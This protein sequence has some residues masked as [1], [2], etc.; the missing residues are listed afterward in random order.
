MFIMKK[1][2]N[3][4]FFYKLFKFIVSGNYSKKFAKEYIKAKNFDNILDIGC[5]TSE[6]LNYLPKKCNYTGIDI[7]QNYIKKAKQIHNNKGTFIVGSFEEITKLNKDQ[8]DLILCIGLL[9]HLNDDEIINL[10]TESK[11]LLKM[12]GRLIT[13]DGCYTKNQPW[14]KKKILSMDRG[15]F[16]RDTKS[17]CKLIDYVFPNNNYNITNNLINIPY[18]HIIFECVK[19]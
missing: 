10:L 11:K 2:L 17:Y 1:V 14:I 12:N 7:N 15:K 18:T 6:I 3:Y 13:F 5:G 9:H 4:A 16:V 8:Y 19:Q